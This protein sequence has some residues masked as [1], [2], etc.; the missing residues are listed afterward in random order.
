MR[1][2]A[3]NA[4]FGAVTKIIFNYVLIIIPAINVKGAVISTIACY[5]VA[6]ILNLRALMK[7]TR[8]RL[9]LMDL[10][11]KPVIASAVM[12][13]ACYGTYKGM[14]LLL[15]RNTLSTL[16]AVAVSMVVYFFVMLFIKGILKEDIYMLPGGRKIASVCEKFS[17]L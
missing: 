12:G 10:I 8:M 9:K 11:F 17:L 6:S 5:V 4:F 16:I 3:I 1:I 7:I 2:P 13:A 14:F 15:H